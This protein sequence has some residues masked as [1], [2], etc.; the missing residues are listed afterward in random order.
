MTELIQIQILTLQ[1]LQQVIDYA[2]K[3]Q[4]TNTQEFLDF[5]DTVNKLSV[6]Y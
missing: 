3:K 1:N 5:L 2:E 6:T 4:L